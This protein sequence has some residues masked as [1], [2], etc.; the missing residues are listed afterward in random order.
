VFAGEPQVDAGIGH[1]TIDATHNLPT[2]P[3]G[4]DGNAKSAGYDANYKRIWGVG[5]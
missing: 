3:G 2:G 5:G 4:Y 1:H